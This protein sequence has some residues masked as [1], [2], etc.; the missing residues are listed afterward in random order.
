MALLH[1][2]ES[3]KLDVNLSGI[4]APNMGSLCTMKG[5]QGFVSGNGDGTVITCDKRQRYFDNTFVIRVNNF[6]IKLT[7]SLWLYL[8]VLFLLVKLAGT[9]C[10]QDK[11]VTD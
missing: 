11:A 3:E 7:N 5:D 10:V 9:H 1:D 4:D 2:R 6:L 8:F